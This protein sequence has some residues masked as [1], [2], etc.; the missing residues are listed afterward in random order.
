METESEPLTR[1]RRPGRPGHAYAACTTAPHLDSTQCD[2]KRFGRSGLP[3]GE[4][5]EQPWV[6]A[7]VNGPT[8]KQAALGGAEPSTCASPKL[9]PTGN[10]Y[11]GT[12][13]RHAGPM[14]A[15]LCSLI[16]LLILPGSVREMALE[17]SALRQQLT[18]FKRH[19]PRPRLRKADRLFWVTGRSLCCSVRG[20]S[21]TAPR[22]ATR[23]P[24][25]WR[26]P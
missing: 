4:L 22:G 19:R 2:W 6:K 20:S 9:C 16:G 8:E 11:F 25:G 3:A 23:D 15:L 24:H 26:L 12:L 7:T 5:H 1:H 21:R 10:S 18:V 14:F 17:N 13:R